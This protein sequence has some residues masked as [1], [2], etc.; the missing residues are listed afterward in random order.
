MRDDIL[1]FRGG[2][3]NRCETPL[4]V[5]MY[6]LAGCKMN[7]ISSETSETEDKKFIGTKE[8]LYSTFHWEELQKIKFFAVQS[9]NMLELLRHK[10]YDLKLT[11]VNQYGNYNVEWLE[12][13]KRENN[14]NT[15][16]WFARFF[17]YMNNNIF[18]RKFWHVSASNLVIEPARH[19]QFK[20]FRLYETVG[21]PKTAS[22]VVV[23]GY[24]RM[25][26]YYDTE[27]PPTEC[28]VFWWKPDNREGDYP[29]IE[30]QLLE[31]DGAHVYSR[32]PFETCASLKLPGGEIINVFRIP[33][34]V[35]SFD[36][37]TACS[38]TIDD[39]TIYRFENCM[40]H[41]ENASNRIVM[42]P[43]V[44]SYNAHFCYSL[45]GHHLIHRIKDT[46]S[47]ATYSVVDAYYTTEENKLQETLPLQNIF[48][49]VQKIKFIVTNPPFDAS[50]GFEGILDKIL[51]TFPKIKISVLCPLLTFYN[52][53]D[54]IL[55]NS[56]ED[57]LT[58]DIPYHAY[59]F[60]SL[61][62]TRIIYSNTFLC[63]D[64]AFKMRKV[65]VQTAIYIYDSER[66]YNYVLD[67]AMRL[68]R[69]A[70]DAAEEEEEKEELR[71]KRRRANHQ[72]D[73]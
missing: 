37:P 42:D 10:T 22:R 5:S 40:F 2:D 47:E 3:G 14:P 62:K 23:N 70:E 15:M 56:G 49:D 4:Q 72:N 33:K 63:E 59:D 27:S 64:N 16:T 25:E 20:F 61:R 69:Q 6:M 53:F 31:N 26:L 44:G 66:M 45:M 7:L 17:L 36:S 55:A 57:G 68:K 50:L 8:L 1:I 46:E 39:E 19:K 41:T 38:F 54:F 13:R 71:R 28:R 29:V 32:E 18:E 12:V 43:F 48:Q 21:L 52:K 67:E 11:N 24:L 65:N 9:S 58:F 51:G 35:M 73:H 30:L 60:D 34:V